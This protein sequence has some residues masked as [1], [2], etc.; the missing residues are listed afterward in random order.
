MMTV[1]GDLAVMGWL[2]FMRDG[3][4]R[5]YKQRT[6]IGIRCTDVPLVALRV[7]SISHTEGMV[8]NVQGET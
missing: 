1:D 8:G 7:E 4:M 6:N 5:R 2:E 3:A